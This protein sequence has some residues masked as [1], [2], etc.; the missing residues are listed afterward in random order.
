M[1][2]FRDFTMPYWKW[3]IK[4]IPPV[5]KNSTKPIDPSNFLWALKCN[6][7]STRVAPFDFNSQQDVAEILQVVLDELKGVSLAAGSLISNTQRTTVS[8]HNYLCS[9]ISEENLDILPWQVSTDIQT[10]INQFPSLKFY[11]HRTND[12]ALHARLF[13]RALE[14]HV[15]WT[16]LLL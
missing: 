1:Q 6:F 11:H 7:S 15:L 13:L 9:S 2:N 16:L 10:S 8:Y 12:F 5:K 3:N 14:K 4:R